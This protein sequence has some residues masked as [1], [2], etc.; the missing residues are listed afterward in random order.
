MIDA[1]SQPIQWS[2]DQVAEVTFYQPQPEH[3]FRQA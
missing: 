2:D 1:M 3:P